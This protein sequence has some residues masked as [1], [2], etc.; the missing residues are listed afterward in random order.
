MIEKFQNWSYIRMLPIIEQKSVRSY[1]PGTNVYQNELLVARTSPVVLDKSLWGQVHDPKYSDGYAKSTQIQSYFSVCVYSLR[2]AGMISIAQDQSLEKNISI[3]HS[4]TLRQSVSQ[5]MRLE[6]ILEGSGF[7]EGGSVMGQL[8]SSFELTQEKEYVTE[9]RRTTTTD[10][11]YDSTG[12]D[13]DVVLWD[14]AKVIVLYRKLKEA[15][16]SPAEQ[17][18]GLTD[19]Y[20]ETYQKTYMVKD[21]TLND[22]KESDEICG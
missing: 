8:Q 12:C 10:I 9:D 2:R 20:F 7:L 1:L 15:S 19:Y 17:M 5:S 6:V 22:E 13:R 4:S 18:V 11:R 14:V 16:G 21:E 3:E